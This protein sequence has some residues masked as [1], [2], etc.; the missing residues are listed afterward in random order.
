MSPDAGSNQLITV[1]GAVQKLIDFECDLY[2]KTGGALSK[3]KA[4]LA[5]LK[6]RI[7]GLRLDLEQL[8]LVQ[9]PRKPPVVPAELRSKPV[10]EDDLDNIVVPF[11]SE[12]VA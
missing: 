9:N 11:R 2:N 6:W 4:N 5:N 7:E 1:T 8:D 3:A 10:I 12:R